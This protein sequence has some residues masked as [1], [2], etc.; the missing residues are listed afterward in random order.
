MDRKPWGLLITVL[1]E[2]L[3]VALVVLIILS[4][5][6]D[7]GLMEGQDDPEP[8]YVTAGQLNGRAH[9]SKMASVEARFD[10]GDRLTPTGN[11]SRDR[12]WV[13]V[14]GGET[15]TV[16]VSIQ[17]VTERFTEFTVTNENNG[18]IRIHSLPGGG[19][20][21]GYIG[22]GKSV[23]IIQVVLGWGR[24]AKGWIDLDYL[25]EEVDHN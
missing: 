22:R 16:W 21:K 9:P 8:L 5:L 14:E 19:K 2:A 20:L 15:G 23:E 18:R 17:Y 13:E 6:T 1:A 12:K 10:Y 3:A 25:I 4:L 24:C 7:I 11:I